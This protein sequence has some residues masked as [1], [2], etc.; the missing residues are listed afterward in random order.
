MLVKGLTA[1]G[2]LDSFRMGLGHQKEQGMI[3]GLELS[4]PHPKPQERERGR[5][6][7]YLP[8]ANEGTSHVSIMKPP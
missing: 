8:M 4:A 2:F 1:G 7:S 5:G 3:R 6:L